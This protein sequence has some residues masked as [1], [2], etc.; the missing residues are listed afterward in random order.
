MDVVHS[1]GAWPAKA[2]ATVAGVQ[3]RLRDAIGARRYDLVV[4]HRESL[5]IGPAWFERALR[6]MGVPYAFDFDDAIYL[7]AASD[8]NRRLAWLKGAVKTGR[9]IRDA[10]L[11]LAGN[12]YLADWAHRHTTRVM[13][14]PTTIDTEA[15]RPVARPTETPL[16]VGWSGSP[17]TIVHL[18][19]LERVLRELQQERGIRIRVIGDASYRLEGAAVEALA[20][21]PTNEVSDLS[22]I[23]IGVMPLPDDDWSRGKCGLKAL[24]YM[25]LGIPTVLSPVGV[26][27][28]IA[29][30]G[31]AVLASSDDEWRE[32][33]RALIDDDA[34]ERGWA[35]R[36]GF[37]SRATIP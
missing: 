17:T 31:A 28:E 37:V 9:V 29:E 13:V 20:W 12:E 6:G 30:G 16:C 35:R 18:R 15:Y 8:A 36:A 33:L 14:I 4:V 34:L 27:R 1:P 11:V 3:R 24:Q 25:A 26:N 22:R 19:L 7:P 2:A 32:A 23:D 5:P 21:D 10:S